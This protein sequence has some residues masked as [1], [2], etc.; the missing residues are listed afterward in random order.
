MRGKGVAPAASLEAGIE[1]GG[2]RQRGEVQV[3][4]NSS[5]MPVEGARVAVVLEDAAEH[6]AKLLRLGVDWLVPLIVREISKVV[7][8]C[9][10]E[11]NQERDSSWA[12]HFG[13]EAGRAMVALLAA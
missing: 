4:V 1:T 12:S 3:G 6:G 9:L 5:H 2:D 8:V 13:V 7:K 10:L 11:N